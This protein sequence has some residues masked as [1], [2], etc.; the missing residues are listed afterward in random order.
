MYASIDQIIDELAQII[1]DSKKYNDPAGY[2]AALYQKVTI[3][4]RDGILNVEFEDNARME[5]LDVLFASRYL[6]AY[7]QFK[8]GQLPTQ[9][10]AV[11]FKASQQKKGIILQHLLL[12]MNAH[13]NLDLGIAAVETVGSGK[14]KVLK[15]DFYAINQI[16]AQM[17]DDVQDSI[18]KASPLFG[19]LDPLTGRADEDLVNFS[20]SIARDGAW[21]FAEK[22]YLARKQ[23]KESIIADRDFRIAVLAN[24]LGNPKSRWL[25]SIL[26]V[27]SWLEWTN[28]TRVIEV[29]SQDD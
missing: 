27:I 8:K 9:S 5:K 14:L 2:F 4:V 19:I 16:L 21:E 18:G 3:R 1:E 28:T 22:L 29:L 10:W 6:D 23:E 26:R 7:Q 20:I 13:I 24:N 11:A 15:N 12:G 25:R 17:V